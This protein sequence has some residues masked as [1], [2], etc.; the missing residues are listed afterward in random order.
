MTGRRLPNSTPTNAL[1]PGD[2]ALTMG[3]WHAVTPSEVTVTLREAQV[4]PDLQVSAT[5]GPWRL[6][7]GT[8]AYD[9]AWTA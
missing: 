5:A 7:Q 8:W 1:L 6:V 3:I 2:Y 9:E 4:H